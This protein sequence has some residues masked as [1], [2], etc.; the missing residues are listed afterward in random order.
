MSV[1]SIGMASTPTPKV[2]P[3]RKGR[4]LKMRLSA[5]SSGILEI[6]TRS[7]ISRTNITTIRS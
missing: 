5:L 3:T 7:T 6:T 1:G 4:A 2:A